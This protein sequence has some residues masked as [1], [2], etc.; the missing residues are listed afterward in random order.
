[1]EGFPYFVIIGESGRYIGGGRDQWA[2]TGYDG[3]DD[4]PGFWAKAQGGDQ[5]RPYYGTC[6]GKRVDTN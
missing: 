1:M 4:R 6:G 2:P 5:P 3:Q